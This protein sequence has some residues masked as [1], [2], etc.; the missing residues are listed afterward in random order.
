MLTHRNG[1][2]KIAVGS[3]V[4]AG[5]ALFAHPERLSVVDARRDGDLERLCVP[6]LALA[7]A[8]LAG[9]L[10]HL[11]RAAAL[12]ARLLRLHRHAHEVL[13]R[14][15]RAGAAAIRTGFRLRAVLAARAMAR[16]T[17]LDARIRNLLLAAERRVL[18]ADFNLRNDILPLAGTRSARGR[19]AGAAA[20]E[21]AENIAEIS[22]A[23]EAAK[24]AEAC[25]RARV[26]VEVRIDT[27]EAVL[28]VARLFVRVGQDLIR[29]IDFLEFFLCRFIAGVLVRVVLHGKLPVSLLDLRIGCVFLDAQN[30]IIISF[31]LICHIVSPLCQ[32]F[33]QAKR[34]GLLRPM[35]D[36]SELRPLRSLRRPRR[37]RPACC[38]P[39]DRSCRN[40]RRNLRSDRPA[41]QRSCRASRRRRR[42]L[43]EPRRSLP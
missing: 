18:K 42:T 27:R 14:A 16:R 9:I 12:R 28:V 4:G 2:Q 39:A 43:S 25:A 17:R 33:R 13:L 24:P 37:R 38:R 10:D 32:V 8:G 7:L 11:A 41:A 23:A 36:A 40:R 19:G 5:V 1:H 31:V 20:E 22:E 15:H 34:G 21:V 30:L 3:A 29:L 26:R 35:A 6:D